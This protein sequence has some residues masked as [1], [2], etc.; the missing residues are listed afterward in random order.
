[1]KALVQRVAHAS[2]TVEG[3]V[4][5]RIGTGLLVLLGATHTDGDADV[6]WL[7][8][9]VAGL[10]VFADEAGKM[11][12]DVREAGG[13]VLVVPQF[14]LYGDARHGKRPEFTAAARPEIAEPL[15][16]RFCEELTALGVP[17]ERGVFRAHML[18]ELLNEGPVTLMIESP[19]GGTA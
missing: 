1:M 18:V 10:R 14:T 4:T 13:G 12:R 8:A 3:T 19:Q 15:Y 2:V 17:V 7:A 11:N 9:K 5:G 16:V 6:S